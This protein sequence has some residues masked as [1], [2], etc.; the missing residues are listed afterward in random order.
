MG[1]EVD[2]VRATRPAPSWWQPGSQHAVERAPWMSTVG[3]NVFAIVF[4]GFIL[5][6][7]WSHRSPVLAVVDISCGVVSIALLRWRR[8]YPAGVAAITL[9]LSAV[10]GAAAGASVVALFGATLRSPRRAVVWLAV[11]SAAATLIYPLIYPDTSGDRGY[12]WQITLGLLFNGLVVGWG[13]FIRARQ[14][15]LFALRERSERLERE[16]E[17]AVLDARRAERRRI[18]REMHDV[19]AHRVSLLSLHAGALE[20][21]PDAPREDIAS[22]ASI[23]RDNAQ[24]VLTELRDVIGLLRED[25]V[26]PLER[27]QPTLD[28][29][30]QLIDESH[31]AGMDIA[32][33]PDVQGSVPPQIGRA[34]YRIIQEGLTNARKHA[35]GARVAVGVSGRPGDNVD[36]RSAQWTRH[37]RTHHPVPASGG[38]RHGLWTSRCQ[39]TGFHSRRSA[40]PRPR[41]RQLVRPAGRA[42]VEWTFSMSTNVRV[43]LVD[44]DALVRAG[45]R[46]ILQGDDSIE[47]VAEADDGAAVPGILDRHR[48]DVVLMD[49]RMP[50]VDGI[51]ATRFV[52]ARPNPPAVIVLTTFHADELVLGALQAGASSFLLKDTAPGEIVAAVHAAARGDS[53]LSPTVTSQLIGLVTGRAGETTQRAKARRELDTLTEREHEIALLVGT[54]RSNAEI[55]KELYVS[56]AT[57]KA[58]VSKLLEKL[59]LDN[60]VQIALL[61]HAADR[62][63]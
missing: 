21:R 51:E 27:P 12:V 7:S 44:D 2:E 34:A 16:R 48:V 54:G 15:V 17:N 23:I 31:A 63:E 11:E 45:L 57:V 46:M 61:V 32:Y 26:D 38:P 56:V 41:R 22:A 53:V 4:G 29:I 58:H 33:T 14:E 5:A 39:G 25:P 52:R 49:L 55:A 62:A 30:P 19:L 20:F 60:R 36:R 18:A 37:H 43:V 24:A 10:S 47:V 50:K 40:R 8:A 9:A 3:A 35:P 59:H 13:L 28:D 42:A 6:I 1:P